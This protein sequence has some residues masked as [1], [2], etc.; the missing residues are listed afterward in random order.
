MPCKGTCFSSNILYF[1]AKCELFVYILTH[2]YLFDA[3]K[4]KFRKLR[5]IHS[6]KILKLINKK[7]DML[8]LRQFLYFSKLFKLL[9]SIKK[10]HIYKFYRNT[11]FRN[12]GYDNTKV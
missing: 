1:D 4:R 8:S 3:L 2:N 7:V 10:S 6:I 9:F 12:S 11:H 5:W